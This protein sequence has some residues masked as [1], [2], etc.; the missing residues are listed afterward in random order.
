MLNA[1]KPGNGPWLCTA[2]SE[3]REAVAWFRSVHPGSGGEAG[4]SSRNL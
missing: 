3:Q 1:I 4:K 2:S